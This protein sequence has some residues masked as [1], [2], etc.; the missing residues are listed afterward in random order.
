MQD[1]HYKYL[2]VL[3]GITLLYLFGM[4]CQFLNADAHVMFYGGRGPFTDEGLYSEAI[5]NYL[6][7]YG[8][9]SELSDA[10]IK[11]PLLTAFV[12]IPLKIFGQKLL[13]ARLMVVVLS[14]AALVYASTYK[15]A[16]P[17]V[18]LFAW[19][20]LFQTY[21]FNYTHLFMAEVPAAAMVV[22]GIVLMYKAIDEK[23]AKVLLIAN[24]LFACSWLLKLQFIYVAAIPV[25]VTCIMLLM[26]HRLFTTKQIGQ[27][28]GVTFGVPLVL[29]F[30]YFIG[31]YYPHRQF[32]QQLLQV[33]KD[34]RLVPFHQLWEN[35]CYN[36]NLYFAT[37]QYSFYVN[38]LALGLVAG[39]PLLFIK[40]VP[41]FIKYLFLVSLFWLLLEFHKIP[42]KY[43]PMRYL[44]STICAS[45]LLCCSVIYG[46]T[47]LA[48][49]SSKKTIKA[50][51]LIVLAVPIFYFAKV[52]QTLLRQALQA[53]QYSIQAANEYI[54]SVY[55]GKGPVLGNWAASLT[56]GISCETSALLAGFVEYKSVLSTYK[57][58][59]IVTEPDQTDLAQ[60]FFKDGIDLNQQAESVKSFK[61]G[62]WT[63]NVYKMKPDIYSR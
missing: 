40:K 31:I 35:V 60:L 34:E 47:W 55:T 42:F 45:G 61:I 4:H 19:L 25:I 10:F 18:L 46:Y 37:P 15:Q 21:V 16:L 43:L 48:L 12:F 24:L 62:E 7:G 28:I 6:N 27:F 2:Y 1:K 5:R 50:I 57:P 59:I 51:A 53:R 38:F 22:A 8:F 33:S 3:L 14:I 41:L 29:G 20:Y 36:Y 32:V 54:A 63:V 56:W 44:I 11:T 13:V 26:Q 9:T 52:N 39:I 58:E 17:V 49:D 23:N 30:V